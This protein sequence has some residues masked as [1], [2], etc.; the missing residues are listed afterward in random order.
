[1]T[2]PIVRLVK[3]DA[4]RAAVFHGFSKTPENDAHQARLAWTQQK[5]L[6]DSRSTYLLLG[7]NNPPPSPGKAE[8][9]YDCMIT[10][11]DEIELE[12]EIQIEEIPAGLYAVVRTNLA[13]M[14][15]QWHWLYNWVENSQYAV[16]GHG[17]EEILC[18]DESD[19][20]TFLFDL[21]L[22]VTE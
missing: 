11:R 8:Y 13:D 1:M 3:I 12:D 20:D 6:L 22:P 5:G 14:E 16:A 7:R 21:W 9:G 4:M 17:L 18:G 19:P 15:K 10:I 2:D